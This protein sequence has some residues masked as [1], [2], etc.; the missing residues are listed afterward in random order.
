M[1]RREFITLIGGGAARGRCHSTPAAGNAGHWIPPQCTSRQCAAFRCRI[2]SG[3]RTKAL[4]RAAASR[5]N[6]VPRKISPIDCRRWSP[7][8]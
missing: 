1:R 3:A 8:F 7:T 5:S 2:S 6:S 4:L